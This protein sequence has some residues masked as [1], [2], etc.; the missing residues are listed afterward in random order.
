MKCVKFT[1]HFQ[2][3][4]GF[5]GIRFENIGL[6]ASVMSKFGIAC[7]QKR[8]LYAV[9]HYKFMVDFSEQG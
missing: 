3:F 5:L 1:G 4:I 9:Q 2:N 6:Q 8:I 7:K